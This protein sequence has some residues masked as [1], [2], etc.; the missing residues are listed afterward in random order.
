M[1]AGDTDHH[2][3][4]SAGFTLLELVVSCAILVSIFAVAASTLTRVHRVRS[5]SKAR[6]RLLAE[7]N[8]ILDSL[9]DDF[10]HAAGTNVWPRAVA[11]RAPS[12]TEFGLVRYEEYPPSASRGKYAGTVPFRKITFSASADTPEGKIKSWGRRPATG[13]QTSDDVARITYSIS[14]DGTSTQ[15][16]A[17]AKTGKA[18]RLLPAETGDTIMVPVTHTSS[19]ETYREEHGYGAITEI[20]AAPDSTNVNLVVSTVVF[21]NSVYYCVSNSVERPVAGAW[22]ERGAVTNRLLS[23]VFL[24]VPAQ[25]TE[26]RGSTDYEPAANTNAVN[27]NATNEISVAGTNTNDVA[28]LTTNGTDIAVTNTNDMA[29]TA[30]NTT[31][32]A[33]VATNTNAIVFSATNEVVRVEGGTNVVVAVS[34]NEFLRVFTYCDFTTNT[35]RQRISVG[36]YVWHF[37]LTNFPPAIATNILTDVPTG[38]AIENS[39]APTGFNNGIPP[40]TIRQT[41]TNSLLCGVAAL[42][43]AFGIETIAACVTP[44]WPPVAAYDYSRTLVAEARSV[45]TDTNAMSVVEF[46]ATIVS[47]YSIVVPV[48]ADAYPTNSLID[49][50][51]T[52]KLVPDGTSYDTDVTWTPFVLEK[53]FEGAEIDMP[54]IWL[55]RNK[56]FEKTRRNAATNNVKVVRYDTISTDDLPAEDINGGGLPMMFGNVHSMTVVLMAFKDGEEDLAVWD[57]DTTGDPVCADIHLELI[58]ASDR[59]KAEAS[60]DKE[61]FIRKHLIS[62]DRRAPIGTARR[63][64]R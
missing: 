23:A 11:Y 10:A 59:R 45:I 39:Y 25:A 40:F 36:D 54:G 34:T 47:S 12:E 61:G 7:G 57:P 55:E 49:G 8:A 44:D 4:T 51:T 27:I 3:K 50:G 52:T 41:S 20:V 33:D 42:D 6:S 24:T 5:E 30:T 22:P 21:T 17:V 60:S 16:Y 2:A 9:A 64:V 48:P 38:N 29:A 56:L 32:Y 19:T 53:D 46:G 18:T 35:P 15:V 13:S 63:P 37:F 58:S 43:A 28:V 1:D 31:V 26:P 14:P 62:L